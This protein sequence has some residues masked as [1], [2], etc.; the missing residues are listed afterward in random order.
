MLSFLRDCP[1]LAVAFSRLDWAVSP[2]QLEDVLDSRVEDILRAIIISAND[3][4][5][6]MLEPFKQILSKARVLFPSAYARL[7]EIVALGVKSPSLALDIML[8][9]LEQESSRLVPERP[10]PTRR[11]THLLNGITINHVEEAAEQYYDRPDLISLKHLCDTEDGWPVV[12]ADFR[13]DSSGG[14]PRTSTHV[15]L[16]EASPPSNSSTARLFSMS[17]LVIRSS[18]GQA[19]FQCFRPVPAYLEDCSWK[20]SCGGPFVTTK[21]MFD[22]TVDLSLGIRSANEIAEMVLGTE[23]HLGSRAEDGAPALTPKK[24]L[25]ERQNKGV[26]SASKHSLTCLWGPPGTGKTHTIVEIIRQLQ[27]QHPKSWILVSA[28]THNAADNVLRRYVSNHVDGNH[29]ISPIRVS[30]EVGVSFYFCAEA[31]TNPKQVRKVSDDLQ[32]YTCDAMA[33]QEVHSSHAA[34]RK[35]TQM[36]KQAR[37]VFTTCIGAALGVLRREKFDIVIIDEAS[38]QTEPASLVPLTKGCTKADVCRFSSE[39]FYD[40]NLRTGVNASERPMPSSAFPWPLIENS[41][42]PESIGTE[43]RHHRMIFIE[44][45][46]P[47]DLGQKSKCSKG[48]AAVCVKVCELLTEVAPGLPKVGSS[49]DTP[50]PFIA[51]LTPY[52]RQVGLLKQNLSSNNLV[53]VCSIDSFQGRE[54]DVIVF[55]TVRC[56]QRCEI[57]FLGDLRRLNVVLTRARTGVIIIGNRATLSGA[58][59]SEEC[60]RTWKKL[61]DTT[62]GVKMGEAAHGDRGSQ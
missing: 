30:T 20:L 1:F 41:P 60:A 35:A 4:G 58:P 47:E 49:A 23:V 57:G 55:V 38:E 33:G 45:A 26:E 40:G 12:R 48:Q 50:K 22:A 5:Q 43:A 46:A 54:A 14:T 51:V 2:A 19:E 7:A 42:R 36:V 28:P 18:P 56:N 31:I 37:I 52:S 13:L 61:I 29:M 17:A 8:G 32:K 25:N 39:V 9:G 15:R 34:L 10:T 6:M 62:K 24:T 16:T 11:I 53:E 44:S 27:I 3:V 59:M 21:A